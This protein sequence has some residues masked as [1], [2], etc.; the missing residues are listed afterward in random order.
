MNTIELVATATAT[1]GDEAGKRASAMA[2]AATTRTLVLLSAGSKAT[3][4]GIQV[5]LTY[6]VGLVDRPEDL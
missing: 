1:T 6:S 3:S 2:R 5:T 4:H